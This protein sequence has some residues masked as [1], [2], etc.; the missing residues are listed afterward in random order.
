MA[1]VILLHAK[2]RLVGR[3]DLRDLPTPDPTETHF[4]I[5]HWRIVQTLAETLAF[6]HLTIVSEEYAVSADGMRFF[7]ALTLNV[8]ETGVRVAI[9]LRN[10]HDK[11]FSM[12]M[13]VGHRV[14]V[15]DNLALFGDYPPVMRKHTKNVEIEEIM[16]SAVDK[17]QRN[18]EPM[19]RQIAFFRGCDLS[20]DRAKLAIYEAFFGGAA[21]LPKHLGQVVHTNYFKPKHPDFEP[22][23]LW[24]LENAFTSALQVLEPVARLRTAGRL[25]PF[26]AKLQELATRAP[27][28]ALSPA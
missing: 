12:G 2:S 24:S 16:S 3:Q 7:A 6:R 28:V 17:V 25:A 20:D 21:D 8:E 10:S 26:L 13:T 15:C 27:L 14:L 22:R 9:G 1:E 18:F 11:S 23:T 5:P 4:P 19:K